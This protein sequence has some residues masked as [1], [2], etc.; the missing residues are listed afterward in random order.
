MGVPVC[1]NDLGIAGTAQELDAL[2]DAIVRDFTD[3]SPTEKRKLC[4]T[5]DRIVKI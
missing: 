3:F 2:Y 4:E 1:L 5:M